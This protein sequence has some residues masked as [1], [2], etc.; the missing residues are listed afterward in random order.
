MDSKIEP[1]T[2]AGQPSEDTSKNNN[3]YAVGEVHELGGKTQQHDLA[4]EDIA[5]ELAEMFQG[6]QGYTQKEVWRLRWKVDLRLIPILWFNVLLPAMDK[7]SHATAALYGLKTDLNLVGNQ[8]AWIGSVFYFGYLVW[9]FPSGSL[10]QKLPIAKTMSGAMMLWGILLIGSGFVKTFSQLMAC[11]FLLGLLEAPI[12]PGNLLILSMW[13]T[14]PEQSLRYGLMYTG[15]STCFTGPIGYAIGF[16]KTDS[17]HVW[18]TFFWICGGMTFL[19]GL[20]VGIFLPD[21]PVKAKF[22][23]EREKAIA[24]DRVRINQTGIENKTFKKEQCIEALLDIRV[25]LM[26][27]FNIW[28]SIPNGG[29][30]NFSPLIVK[31]LGYTSQRSALLT[32]PNGIVQTA[33]SYICNGGVFLAVRYMPQYHFRGAFIMFGVIV[34]LIA[35]IFLYTL[36]TTAYHSRLAALYMSFFYLGP[37]IV[38]L[39]LIGANTAGH[40]KKVTVNAMM[41]IAYCVSN[42]IAPQFFKT[43]QAPL[44]PL[45]FGAILGSYI[46]SLL[47]IGVYMALC[48]YENK[49][50]DARDAAA[51]AVVHQDTDFKDLTDKQNL[52]FRYV[53]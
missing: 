19:Y 21:N 42:I 14:R 27:L 28:I 13:Y 3:D 39:S 8:Y 41:F 51:G 6:G 49:R 16:I 43:A 7:V 23:S 38:A 12:V 44:Y 24:V 11:R 30:T 10:L 9:C 52:H 36:P 40:T 34:G 33:S 25:W 47:T 17:F 18:S 48:W 46:L 53:W 29:L 20:V 2:A 1:T 31:G 45:G 15:L 50:R 37:Y 32:I 22:I 5:A 35:A 4:K 26:F